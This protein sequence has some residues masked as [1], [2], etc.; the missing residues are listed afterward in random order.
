MSFVLRYPGAFQVP[1]ATSTTLSFQVFPGQSVNVQFK[2]ASPCP[3]PIKG[4]LGRETTL[5][6]SCWCDADQLQTE[7][8][9]QLVNTQL[10]HNDHK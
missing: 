8:K 7:W 6:R 9:E 3:L 1:K 10:Q 2:V 5:G 4:R